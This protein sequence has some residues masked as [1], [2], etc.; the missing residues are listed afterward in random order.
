MDIKVK[1]QKKNKK[2]KDEGID[3]YASL[4]AKIRKTYP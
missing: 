4:I 1:Y 3:D 2:I